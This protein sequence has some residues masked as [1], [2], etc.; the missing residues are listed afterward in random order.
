ME[1]LPSLELPNILGGG[2]SS[3]SN[4]TTTNPLSGLGAGIGGIFGS[5]GKGGLVEMPREFSFLESQIPALP[6]SA[7]S[8]ANM[9]ALGA[10]PVR[11]NDILIEK[12]TKRIHWLI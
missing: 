12:K 1:G 5:F 6:S 10:L 4:A 7:P 3:G 8:I 2:D 11:S 9:P